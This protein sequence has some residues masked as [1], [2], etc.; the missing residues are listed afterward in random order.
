MRKRLLPIAVVF[1]LCLSTFAKSKDQRLVLKWP[2]DASPILQVTFGQFSLTSTYQKNNFYAV[3]AEVENVTDKQFPQGGLSLIFYDAENAQIGT[4]NLWIGEGLG[5][6][7]K[8][9]QQISFST[10]GKPTRIAF[11][12]KDVALSANQKVAAHVV[13][14]TFRSIPTGATIEIDGQPFGVAPKVLKV[15]EGSHTVVMTKAGYDKAEYAFEVRPTDGNGGYV[16]V[17]LPT[18]NDI[19]E[20]RDGSTVG[21][22][23]ESITWETVKIIVADKPI[24]Y[25][26][27]L[28]KRITLVQRQVKAVVPPPTPAPA[29]AATPAAKAPAQK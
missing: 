6:H 27:N 9:K 3:D 7:L 28:V 24:E 14:M 10:N 29:T 25:P 15:P 16:E 2:N 17:E 18:S 12:M 23:V 1:I 19:L 13:S 5:P 8:L 26:R 21:G 20:M 11:S 4:A 22:D